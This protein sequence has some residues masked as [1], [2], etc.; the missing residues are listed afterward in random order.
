M[1]AGNLLRASEASALSNSQFIANVEGKKLKSSGGKKFQFSVVFLVTLMIAV[2]A[3]IFTSGN[4][5]P[6]AISERLLEETDVQY[7]DAV[8]S[9]TIVFAEAMKTGDIPK[10]TASRLEENGA[11]II[12][13]EDGSVSVSIDGKVISATEFYDEIHNNSKLYNAFTKAT[14]NRAAYYYDSAAKEV[15]RNI[16]TNRNNYT[17]DSD[18]NETMSNLIGK[19]SNITTNGVTLVKHTEEVDGE[20]KTTY[21]YVETGSAVSS[22]NNEAEKFIDSVSERLVD[23]DSSTATMKA[24]ETLNIADTVSKEQKSSIF[25]LAFMENISKMKA[26]EGSES[27]I[28]EAMNYLN[29]STETELVDTST[30]EVV[31]ISG[32]PLESP[33]L[34]SILAKE[35]LKTDTLNYYMS[36][37]VLQTIE[38]KAGV[39]SNPS[40]L[41]GIATSTSR[42]ISGNIGSFT[43]GSTTGSTE[44]L[45]SV[46]KTINN[47]LINNSFS[48]IHG[49]NAGEMLVEGAV[50]VGKELAKTSGA[51]PGNIDAIK[52]YA[53]LTTKILAMDAE[54]DRMNRSPFDITSKNTFL[55]S[56]IY[57]FAI[58]LKPSSLITQFSSFNSTVF[59]AISSLLPST[60]ADDET[61]RYL[62]NIGNCRT[63]ESIGANGSAVCSEIAI[64][65]TSTLGDIFNDPSF[66]SFMNQ[67]TTLSNGTRT[68]NKGSVLDNFVNYNNKRTTPIGVMDGGILNALRNSGSFSV[69]TSI[70]K[71]VEDLINS[72]DNE[73]RIATGEAFV[74]S[75]SNKDWQTYKY[76]QRY[77][78]LARATESL[79][80]Y[81]N[82]KTAYSNLKFF[83][84]TPTLTILASNSQH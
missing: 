17:A 16:G 80:Q 59:S 51:T 3:L 31:K 20:Q 1:N 61:E 4:L 6:S 68:I 35:P 15:F 73:R 26:G 18:F 57:N 29:K 75:P 63:I 22:N 12:T 39:K 52:S 66:I 78:S 19:G 48:D 2:I 74:N 60:Y 13:N 71:M 42:K 34:Y 23:E 36:D 21:Q 67:N 55:G 53:R 56:I 54:V 37:R 79:R 72:S 27:K 8:E 10:D 24:A 70:T 58:H 84:G 65:D 11:T 45:R 33:S 81:S 69:I 9:K 44:N 5:I 76:A 30:G 46:S 62:G 83:E 25:F 14:Y 43:K 41:R 40:I 28:N 49:I 77:I 38:N 32:T 82:D 7:A 64:F 47:S 50:N